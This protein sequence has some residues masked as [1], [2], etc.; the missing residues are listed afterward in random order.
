LPYAL[1][2]SGL[3]VGGVLLI[4]AALATERSI[5]ILISV[6]HH[7]PQHSTYEEMTQHVLKSRLY[8]TSMEISILL[9]CGGCAVGYII[10]IGDILEQSSL[11]FILNSRT[12]TLAFVWFIAMVPLSL[13]RN[14]Q[15]LQ[16]ASAVGITAIATLVLAAFIHYQQHHYS[17]GPGDSASKFSILQLLHRL[18]H[19]GHP[20]NVFSTSDDVQLSDFLWPMHGFVS[21]L[22]SGPVFVFAF[23]CQANVC[24]IY[25]ELDATGIS[26]NSG[27]SYDSIDSSF[28][29]PTESG[30]GA[31]KLEL[32][33]R[34]TMIA[35]CICAGLYCSI[36]VIALA[37]FGTLVQPNIL[38]CYSADHGIFYIQV[39]TAAMALAVVMAFP[40]NIFP[41][42]VTLMGLIA[43]SKPQENLNRWNH[44][45]LEITP[46]ESLTEALLVDHLMRL[47]HDV[48]DDQYHSGLQPLEVQPDSTAGAAS[49]LDHVLGHAQATIPN[50]DNDTF[51]WT[52]HVATTLFLTGLTLCLALMLPNISIVFGLLGGTASS[53]LGF[54]V[55]GLLGM[56]L[57]NDHQHNTGEK[58]QNMMI[59][60]WAL[61][62][63]GIAIGLLTTGVTIYNTLIS[64]S[65]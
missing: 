34:V 64:P 37:D 21:V 3:I 18:R 33:H 17:D 45:T 26:S 19:V 56:Q 43:H 22:S 30:P 65:N 23:S 13:L 24:S 25:D 62:I 40:L 38:S 50:D 29:R 54:C 58:L 49:A 27:H 61:Y 59:T 14:V 4:L 11:L 60:S 44:P 39:A 7:Y 63:G 57:S 41:A 31:T 51:D 36:S 1:L 12:W 10:A 47:P 55:P 8:R 48:S 6:M 5:H 35:V 46:N 20:N 32:M 53:W 9:F 52:L 42:R 28:A 15:S 16:Y 2:Q